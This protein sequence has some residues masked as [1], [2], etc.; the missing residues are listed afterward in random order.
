MK[1]YILKLNLIINEEDFYKSYVKRLLTVLRMIETITRCFC[2]LAEHPNMLNITLPMIRMTL[3]TV[4]WISLYL[5]W[6]IFKR[7]EFNAVN[8]TG[9][10][11]CENKHYFKSWYRLTQT[12]NRSPLKPNLDFLQ[13]LFKNNNNIV[14]IIN[15]FIIKRLFWQTNTKRIVRNKNKKRN[16]IYVCINTRHSRMVYSSRES[17]RKISWCTSVLSEERRK[18]ERDCRRKRK[19]EREIERK[20]WRATRSRRGFMGPKKFKTRFRERER[21]PKKWKR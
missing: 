15:L 13:G 10:T 20:R 9:I 12:Q 1:V 5:I 8:L 18:I 14:R 6:F 7:I 17:E 19:K 11:A 4:Q 2:M 3:S 21:M 16:K